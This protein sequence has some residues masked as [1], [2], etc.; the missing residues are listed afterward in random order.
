MSNDRLLLTAEVA[1]T[2]G[3]TPRHVARL[4]ETGV[5]EP[6]I[7]LNGLRGALLF[8]A[9]DVEQLLEERQAS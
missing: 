4:A 6:A 5:L 9:A 3:I 7:R 2:L 1:S 8:H